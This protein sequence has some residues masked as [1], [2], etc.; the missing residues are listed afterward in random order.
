LGATAH[1]ADSGQTPLAS[2][3]AQTTT[4]RTTVLHVR[5]GL[6]IIR[7]ATEVVQTAPIV[8]G[9]LQVCRGTRR[10][11]ARVSAAISGPI[12]AAV[13]AACSTAPQRTVV[14]VRQGTSTTLNAPGFARLPTTAREMPHPSLAFTLHA[15][16]TAATRGQGV[17]VLSARLNTIQPITAGCA[18]WA[19]KVSTPT[20]TRNAQ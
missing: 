13:P 15:L 19:T 3:A 5:W 6:K 11:V 16:V 20:A 18:T 9:T 12:L 10:R 14:H 4:P 2:C 1:A 8:A 7:F 17:T